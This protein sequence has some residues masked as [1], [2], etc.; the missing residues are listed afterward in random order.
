MIFIFLFSYLITIG[1]Y[2]VMLITGVRELKKA[3]NDIDPSKS[4]AYKVGEWLGIY[5]VA[6]ILLA[7]TIAIVLFTKAT[8]E[9]FFM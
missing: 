8:Y 1:L 9:I 5:F 2:A 3:I 7:F 6:L 4:F